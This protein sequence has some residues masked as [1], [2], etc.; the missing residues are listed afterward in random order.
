MFLAPQCDMIC[1]SYHIEELNLMALPPTP[2]LKGEGSGD[3]VSPFPF[4]EG[5]WG[6]RWG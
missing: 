3:N 5:G 6:V 4:R 1:L 2:P